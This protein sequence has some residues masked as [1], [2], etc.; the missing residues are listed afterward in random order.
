MVVEVEIL[1]VEKAVPG[2]EADAAFPHVALDDLGGGVAL[3]A[4]RLREI[5]AGIV[6]NIAAA[7]IDE[8][9]HPKH[10]E[11][12]AEAVLDRL[13]VSFGRAPPSSTIR[14]ASFMAS[15]WMRGTM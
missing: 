5:A 3:A 6:E 13:A 2:S 7:P 4:E 10:G 14:A 12:E 15:A 8:L 1:V 9:Q 11:A